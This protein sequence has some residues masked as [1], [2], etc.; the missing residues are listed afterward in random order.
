MQLYFLGTGAGM[1]SRHRNVTSAALDLT[2]EKE[3]IWLFD[4][5]EGTQQQIL[6][7][8][9]KMS[10]INKLFVTHLHG[11][12]VYG[13]PGFLTS[14][15]YQG[16]TS[17]FTLYG[18][19]GVKTFIETAFSISD[20]HVEYELSIVEI[21]PGTIFTDG[22]YTVHAERLEHRIESF[23]YRIEEAN[24]PGCLDAEQLRQ[25]G[26]PN[27][28]L[29]GRLKKGETITLEDGRTLRGSDFLGPGYYG[30]TVVILGDTR[31]CEAAKKLSNQADVVVHEA[32]FAREKSDLATAYY[33]ATAEQAA[34]TARDA[35]ARHLILTHIS[36][37]YEDDA[38]PLLQEAR[39][40]FGESYLARD[41]WSFAVERRRMDENKEQ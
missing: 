31:Y 6:K 23:G 36:Q 29:Y 14:R 28:P 24:K 16:G 30:R 11:D 26:V 7:S 13:L 3:G 33:H 41:F 5:G 8:P 17:P 39:D 10:K 15:G 34:I 38:E 9:L 35:G 1:P 32:T 37:R 19:K 21:E 27:G 40:I 20:A 25:L 22:Q 18:P 4:C 12:H 2:E